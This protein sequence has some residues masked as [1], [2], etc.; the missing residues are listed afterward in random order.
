MD[1][2]HMRI[3]FDEL[4]EHYEDK[5]IYNNK[6]SLLEWQAK[7]EWLVKRLVDIKFTTKY[8]YINYK[9]QE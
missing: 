2:E 3:V 6:D 7:C 9:H 1:T 8:E 5:T 4:I